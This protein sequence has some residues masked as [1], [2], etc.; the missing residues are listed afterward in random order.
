MSNSRSHYKERESTRD[1]SQVR[2]A[3]CSID[4]FA[5]NYVVPAA[6]LPVAFPASTKPDPTEEAKFDKRNSSSERIV[7]KGWGVYEEGR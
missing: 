4:N 5:V 2:T 3:Q 7:R 1:I 6:A